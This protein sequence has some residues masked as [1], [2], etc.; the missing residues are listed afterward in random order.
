MEGKSHEINFD[1]IHAAATLSDQLGQRVLVAEDTDDE[2]G[3][4]AAMEDGALAYL[5]FR[6]VMKDRVA[7]DGAVQVV[8]RP[9]TGFAIDRELMCDAYGVAQKAIF[10]I[11]GV[12][13]LNLYNY[14]GP[15]PSRKEAKS[16]LAERVESLDGYLD[17]FGVFTRLGH[18]PPQRSTADRLRIAGRWIISC[19]LLPLL[20]TG[21]LAWAVVFSDKPNA[22]SDP[23]FGLLVITGAAVLAVPIMLTVW[24]ATVILNL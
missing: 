3:M 8:Y 14:A 23:G 16:V 1:L 5:R 18:A 10:D 20:F 12:P 21:I 17:S 11:Y 15:K 7:Q 6:T 19:A 2:Y 24:L 13:Q 22:E 9:D 4:A